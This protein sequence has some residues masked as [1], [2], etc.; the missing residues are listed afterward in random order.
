MH[1][2]ILILKNVCI[3]SVS[4]VYYE[5]FGINKQYKNLFDI[6]LKLTLPVLERELGNNTISIIWRTKYNL[7]E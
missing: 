4:F 3:L 5:M 1:L 6:A 7:E 2:P